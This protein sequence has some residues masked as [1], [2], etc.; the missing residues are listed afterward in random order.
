M[1]PNGHNF[2]IP[3]TK[4]EIKQLK[5]GKDI[6]KTF[7]EQLE[8]L[9]LFVVILSTKKYEKEDLKVFLQAG[10]NATS[11]QLGKK[12][13]RRLETDF[14]NVIKISYPAFQIFVFSEQAEAYNQIELQG[15]A[16]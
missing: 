7:H 8:L 3:L 13:M 10:D 6:I 2:K 11:I 15:D 16:V 14:K 5:Q 1:N 4:K 9:P 12:E